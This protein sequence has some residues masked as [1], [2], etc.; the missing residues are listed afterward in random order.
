[1]V[2][3]A[4]VPSDSASPNTDN[5]RYKALTGQWQVIEESSQVYDSTPF[6]RR[7]PIRQTWRVREVLTVR[8]VGAFGPGLRLG[9]FFCKAGNI[10]ATFDVLKES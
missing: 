6:P 3:L 10:P 1:M 5:H 9:R 7:R 2:T 4:S 8:R